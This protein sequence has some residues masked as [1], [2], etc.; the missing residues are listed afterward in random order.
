[1]GYKHRSIQRPP[2]PRSGRSVD[3]WVELD[4]LQTSLSQHRCKRPLLKRAAPLGDN[5]HHNGGALGHIV[6][7]RKKAHAAPLVTAGGSR[8]IG[9]KV[10]HHGHPRREAAVGHKY[11]LRTNFAT[12][13]R[14]KRQAA[15]DNVRLFLQ[16]V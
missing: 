8:G 7:K 3:L 10:M 11:T 1:M 15:A 9:P 6:Y 14:P 16:L 2:H 12:S 5:S 13:H 4:P